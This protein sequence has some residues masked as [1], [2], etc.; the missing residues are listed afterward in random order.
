MIGAF[1]SSIGISRS[2]RLGLVMT[3]AIASIAL[4]SY[5]IGL[6]R[7]EQAGTSPDS[8]QASRFS[9]LVEQLATSGYGAEDSG[10]WGDFGASWNRIYS[11]ASAPY[12]AALAER[13][14]NGSGSSLVGCADPASGEL[15]CYPLFDNQDRFIG[16]VD[17][18]N[19]NA[20]MPGDTFSAQWQTCNEANQYCGT[21]RSVAETKDLSTGLVWSPILG[22]N[23]W[24]WANNCAQPGS[25]L[26]PGGACSANGD[27][28]CQCVKIPPPAEDGDPDQTGCENYDD[29]NWRLPSQKEL[30]QAYINGS[31]Q[32]LSGSSH[33]SATTVSIF[34]HQAWRV[35]LSNGNTF[36][37]FKTTS[38]SVRCVR[39]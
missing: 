21:N 37:N 9:Q 29:G 15:T 26:N 19:N 10:S 23:N 6:V 5:R 8:G 22:S 39:S 1:R 25:T 13:L 2:W 17:D 31:W 3:I 20:T 28:T 27:Q 32:N 18:Y 35:A 4:L 14:Y 38:Y 30:M 11:A 33:W 24:W 34:T 7:A 12:N 16:G 36:V